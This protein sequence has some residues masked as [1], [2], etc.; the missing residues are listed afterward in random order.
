MGRRSLPPDPLLLPSLLLL[1]LT[2]LLSARPAPAG[3]LQEG[4]RDRR[5]VRAHFDD[6]QMVAAAAA[7]IAPWNVNDEQGYLVAEVGDVEAAALEAIG[8]R[9][10]LDAERT[11]RLNRPNVRLPGQTSGI[12]GFPCYRTVEETYATGA[13]LAQDHPE[14]ATWI[15]AG[16]SWEKLNV[17]GAG[18]DL[19][20]LRLTN[21]AVAGPKPQL[22]AMSS[23]HAR[24]Y[25]PAEM[26]TR[27]AEYLLQH[28]GVHPDVTWLLDYHELHLLLQANPDGRKQAENGLAWRKN[29]N[30]A[31]CGADSPSRGADLN[32]NYPFQWGCCGGSSAFQCSELYRGSAPSSEPE[33]QAVRDYVR[34][35]FPDRRDDALSAAAPVTT[36]GVF[37]D[38]HSYGGD[39]LWPWGFV[40]QVA[41]NGTALQTL[42]RKLAYFNGYNPRQAVYLY[43]TDG[44][45]DDFTYGELGMA[46][47]AF[48]MGTRFFESCTAFEA[49][50]YPDNLAALLYAAKAARA[51]Y[52]IPAGPDALD[53]SL[54]PA[55]VTSGEPVTLTARL[56]DGRFSNRNGA[57]PVQAIAA[58]AYTVG[59][60]PWLTAT[61]PVTHP[62][63]ATDGAF[64]QPQEW[65]TAVVDTAALPPGRHLIY[66][67]G[68]DAAGNRGAVSAVFLEVTPPP[69]AWRDLYFPVLQQ[70]AGIARLRQ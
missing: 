40:D 62:L 20:V 23:V 10:E 53:L 54:S 6:R 56:D 39:V 48:E 69:G 32:R 5:V 31:Y 7:W 29:T 36:T 17:P 24:E 2:L 3:V 59:A 70:A 52:Q 9:L 13:A 38:L 60:P 33:T 35:H 47:L 26:N 1:A 27:F 21:D 57:E 55:Q 14:L 28:Y 63:A 18:Y 30:R 68:Q 37:L 65:A 43:P 11:R 25:T 64:N 15:D 51:P 44:T 45:T 46:A 19:H 42:G 58:A 22:F 34:A 66:V 67:Q 16:D 8:F 12:P 49:I 4:G 41:P 61:V 50:V